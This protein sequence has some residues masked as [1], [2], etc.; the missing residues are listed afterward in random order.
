M[1]WNGETTISLLWLFGGQTYRVNKRSS[2]VATACAKMTAE[3]KCRANR[4]FV[5]PVFLVERI[6]LNVMCLFDIGSTN[7]RMSKVYLFIYACPLHLSFSLG[8]AC[9]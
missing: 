4:L 7:V 5:L 3:S 9:C 6:M 8:S 1:G 2:V